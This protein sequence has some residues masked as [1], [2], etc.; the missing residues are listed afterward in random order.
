MKN[1]DEITNGLLERRDQ[2]VAEQKKRRKTA[3]TVT[4]SLCCFC[5]VAL[6]GFGA[7]NGGMFGTTPPD[8]IK[9]SSV[10]ADEMTNETRGTTVP[11]D[12]NSSDNAEIPYHSSDVMGLVV[13]D[14]ITY[15]QCETDVEA[16]S[17]DT[18]L[19]NVSDYD[20]TYKSDIK[21]TEG[22]LYTTKEDSDILILK[23]ENGST[24]ALKKQFDV[25]Y[26]AD[27]VGCIAEVK[28]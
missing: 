22:K 19:G 8:R 12:N 13:V 6:L 23:L 16:Y 25:K 28:S 21:D 10:Y 2:Y 17:L 3:V 5:L 11:T 26:N 20:G 15:L 7:W 27:S 24:I 1:Y 14:G 18:Y 4:T 9:D